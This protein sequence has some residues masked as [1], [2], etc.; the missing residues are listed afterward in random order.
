MWQVVLPKNQ[1]ISENILIMQQ[2]HWTV[3]LHS[4]GLRRDEWFCI[5]NQLPGAPRGPSAGVPLWVGMS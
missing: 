2:S 5:S 4:E 3:D 1:L